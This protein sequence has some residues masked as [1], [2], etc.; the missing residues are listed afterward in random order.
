MFAGTGGSRNTAKNVAYVGSNACAGCHTA[1]FRSFRQTAMGRSMSPASQQLKSLSGTVTVRS[2]SL[3]RYFSVFRDGDAAYQSEYQLTPEGNEV[4]RNTQKLEYAIGSGINGFTYIVRRGNSLVEAPLSYYSR[5]GKWYLSPGYETE[6]IGFSRPVPAGC[7]VCHSGKPQPLAAQTGTYRDPPFQELAIGCENCHGPGALH[8]AERSAKLPLTVKVDLSIVNPARLTPWLADNVC[9]YC[10]QGATTRVLQPGKNYDDFRP[11]T[12]LDETMAIFAPTMKDSRTPSP[13]LEHYTLMTMSKCYRGSKGSM[14]C[15]TC[16]DPHSEPDRATAAAY[17]RN[18][19]FTCHTDK[20]CRLP[21]TLRAAN[22]CAG[23]H[24]PKRSLDKIPHS[25]LTDHRVIKRPEQA[26]SNVSIPPGVA[27]LPG[28]VHVNHVPGS[29]AQSSPITILRAYRELASSQPLYKVR[30]EE[31][32]GQ[33]AKTNPKDPLVLSGLAYLRLES[34]SYE[35][36]VEASRLLEGAITAGSTSPQDFEVLA[37]LL[38]ESGRIA[39]AAARLE[40]GIGVDPNYKRSYKAL[41]L[42]YITQKRY[43]D[44]LRTMRNYLALFPED[45]F[46]RTLLSKV[47]ATPR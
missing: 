16:H 27:Q 8:V 42:I 3:N 47:E 1:I 29:S 37:G 17:F 25:V 40:R 35:A 33:L 28:L 38:A 18:K 24:L 12:P 19:C 2:D 13:L 43:E 36:K 15:T 45:S 7:V 14:G 31:Q 21:L 34:Q 5:A 10:H 9:M 41:T 46:M 11:G 6:D 26:N 22:D 23:C 44:A 30:Y 32:L 4:F 39:D 20:S